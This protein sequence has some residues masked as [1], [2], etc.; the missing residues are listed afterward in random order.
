MTKD[1]G[2]WYVVNSENSEIQGT[3]GESKQEATDNICVQLNMLHGLNCD[4]SYWQ[5]RGYKVRKD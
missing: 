2:K 5:K 1:N 3:R 4:W